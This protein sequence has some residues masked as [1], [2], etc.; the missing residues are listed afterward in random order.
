MAD[1]MGERKNYAWIAPCISGIISIIALLTPAAY[2]SYFGAS[3][4]LWIWGLASL[5]I[6]GYFTYTAFSD[7][8]LILIPSVICTLILIVSS[9]L[10]LAKTYS[11]KKGSVEIDIAK[12]NWLIASILIII[13]TIFWM[14]W[15]EISY[16][17]TPNPYGITISF[18]SYVNPGFGV[19]GLFIGGGITIIGVIISKNLESR[20]IQQQIIKT[21][22]PNFCPNCGKRVFKKGYKFCTYC[23]YKFEKSGYTS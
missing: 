11:Y 12:K 9:I 22:S 17:L 21:Y 19:I 8:L 23:G 6:P 10:I 3:F 2:F 1:K 7:N 20:S 18:W 5:N 16:I 4:N 13:V 14:V 15:L